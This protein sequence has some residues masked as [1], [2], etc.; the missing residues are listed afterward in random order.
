MDADQLH[1]DVDRYR[2]VLTRLIDKCNRPEFLDREAGLYCVGDQ[3]CHAQALTL[4]I[5]PPELREKVAERLIRD[6]V[7]TRHGH[8][9]TGFGGTVYL[10]KAL[11]ERNRSDIA[12]SVAWRLNPT[13]DCRRIVLRSKPSDC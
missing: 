1:A 4:D 6:L 3:G 5:V 2:E 10:L 8:L 11:I 9:N 7:E 12:H 13:V